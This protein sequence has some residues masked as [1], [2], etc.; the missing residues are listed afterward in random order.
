MT[1]NKEIMK[2]EST[3]NNLDYFE[4]ALLVMEKADKKQYKDFLRYINQIEQ[5]PYLN[6]KLRQTFVDML[7][8]NEYFIK[9]IFIIATGSLSCRSL[10]DGKLTVQQ[11]HKLAK[12]KLAQIKK[13]S[14][15]QR[16]TK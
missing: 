5:E 4:H 6:K 15:K 3:K 1:K 11:I 12:I 14:A 10:I 7:I 13:E 2:P 8:L 9:T 16:K